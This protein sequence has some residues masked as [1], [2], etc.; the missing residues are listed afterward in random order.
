MTTALSSA[1]PGYLLP[2]TPS[3]LDDEQLGRRLSNLI[4]GVTGLPGAM[5][6]PR[7]QADAPPIPPPETDWAAVGVTTYPTRGGVPYLQHVS[8]DDGHDVVHDPSDLEALVTF[9]G[10]GCAG[11]ARLV[12]TALW[13]GQSW[14]QLTPLGISLRDVGEVR[15]TAEKVNE[16]FYRRADFVLQLTQSVTR[17]YAIL[18]VLRADG[19]VH[20]QHGVDTMVDVKFD[21][22]NVENAP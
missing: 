21:T 10:P 8:D 18:N 11:L 4:A 9:Y 20:A 22:E 7:W 14:E 13:V 19:E 15:V 17:D 16:R 2:T 6:R 3:P 1:Y 12:T 5:V